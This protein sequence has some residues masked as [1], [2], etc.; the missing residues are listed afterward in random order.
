MCKLFLVKDCRI[1]GKR[2]QQ[3][4]D[5]G[6]EIGFSC[7]SMSGQGG[8]DV[9]RSDRLKRLARS[10]IGV[11]ALLLIQGFSA[12]RLAWAGCNH[13]VVSR[14]DSSMDFNRLDEL[15]PARSASFSADDP[16]RSPLG[17][18]VPERRTPCTGMSC[19]SRAP[20]PA[21]TVSSEPR[22][23]DQ[24]GALGALVVPEPLL[25]LDR[26]HEQPISG[27]AGYK[28]SI[29]HPPPLCPLIASNPAMNLAPLQVWR[30]RVALGAGNLKN[31]RLPSAPSRRFLDRWRITTAVRT[32]WREAVAYSLN[33]ACH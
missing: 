24:W 27:R 9:M 25:A 10:G 13:L 28:P 19:S 22:N 31:A 29:F 14:L 7:P 32:S 17:P 16:A 33:R 26:S 5:A 20:L 21:S 8:R 15:V 18:G 1:F 11:L 4:V 6:I 12:P 2:H 30:R 23:V 3:V